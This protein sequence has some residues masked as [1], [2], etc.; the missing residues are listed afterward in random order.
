[1]SVRFFVAIISCYLIVFD[2][3]AQK[4]DREYLLN[5]IKTLSSSAFSGR[6]PGTKGHQKALAYLTERF[7]MLQLKSFQ[8]G[9]LDTFEI[10]DGLTGHN[11]IGYIPGK[12][13]GAIVISGHYDHLGERN[14]QIYYGAD[15][16]ASGA[17]ALLAL[18]AYFSQR[19]PNHTLIFAA[20]DAEE[21]GLRGARAFV[22]KPP[23]PLDKIILHINMD[24][25]S[26][27]DNNELYA[28]GT[29]HYPFLLPFIK[30]GD[31][32]VTVKTG[33]DQPGS[34][35]DDWTRQSDHAAFHEAGIP[36]IYF[37]VEDH[38][39]YHTPRDTYER[40][41]PDFFYHAVLAILA[42]V[43]NIDNGNPTELR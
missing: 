5:D 1:M 9:Y 4:I 7:H 31:S 13:E 38:P 3:T 23:I 41:Q 12:R 6:K 30:G 10:K 27:N 33:H 24:M 2:A 26:R 19:Q 42:T 15:D 32:V 28:C 36:F 43:E 21:M 17:S 25:V 11:I 18:A 22:K 8:H 16:N 35:H 40:I 29:Y 39:D 34:G 20:F 14:G 37:G